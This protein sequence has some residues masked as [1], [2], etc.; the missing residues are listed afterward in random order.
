LPAFASLRQVSTP[1]TSSMTGRLFQ[2]F[3][4]RGC[5]SSSQPSRDKRIEEYWLSDWRGLPFGKAEQPLDRL[6]SP[7]ASPGRGTLPIIR[8]P[9]CLH[10]GYRRSR[11]LDFACPGP[12]QGFAHGA[13]TRFGGFTEMVS[14]FSAFRLPTYQGDRPDHQISGSGSIPPGSGFAEAWEGLRTEKRFVLLLTK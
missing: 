7:H 4:C 1:L 2:E 13:L 3:P 8:R 9:I 6:S 10:L 11:N 14:L 5:S 12:D